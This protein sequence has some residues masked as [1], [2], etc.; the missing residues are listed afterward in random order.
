MKNLSL[1]FALILCSSSAYAQNAFGPD[2][3]GFG[4]STNTTAPGMFG[5][6]AGITQS[7]FGINIGEIFFRA[8]LTDAFE[9][10]FEAGSVFVNDGEV[11]RSAQF[12]ILKHKV[13]NTK[14]GSLQVSLLNRTILPFLNEDVSEYYTQFFALVDFS[15]TPELSVNTNLGYGN[16]V[17]SDL[18][19][20][21]F[22]FT[23]NPG[24]VITPGT[25]VYLG[26]GYAQDEFFDFTNYELG[27]AHMIHA[28]SQVD[29][30]VVFDDES[31]L[32]LKAGIATRF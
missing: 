32:Y 16:F 3:P 27:I 5:L 15:L 13:F 26:L 17:F 14:D 8:G 21:A 19:N 23:I 28:N 20:A 9:I 31:N 6:E 4:Y 12:L 30:G 18:D 1:L 25:S 29:L 11:D 2:R 24:Y 22:Y 7:E 10:Q